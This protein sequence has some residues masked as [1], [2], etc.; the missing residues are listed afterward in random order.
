MLTGIELAYGVGM[1]TT[2]LVFPLLP[3]LALLPLLSWRML[4]MPP[5][6]GRPDANTDEDEEDA[7]VLL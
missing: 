5:G 7:F 3:P 2:R 4:I 1:G 6:G